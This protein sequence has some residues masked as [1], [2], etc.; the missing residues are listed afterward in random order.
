M[1]CSEIKNHCHPYLDRQLDAAQCQEVDAHLSACPCCQK[2]FEAQRTFLVV[3]KKLTQT[4]AGAAP[5][6]LR[7]RISQSLIAGHAQ[8]EFKPLKKPLA[9]PRM[10]W[11]VGMAASLMLGFSALLAYQMLCIDGACPI[12][13][14]AEQEHEKI[15]SGARAVLAKDSDAKKLTAA[16]QAQLPAFPGLPNLA[17]YNL[18]PTECGLVNLPPLQKTTGNK[19]SGVFVRYVGS[20][21]GEPLTLMMFDTN[22]SS[23]APVVDKEA[24]YHMAIREK[25]TV[26]SWRCKKSG[27][28]YVLVTR[29]QQGDSL[30]IAEFASN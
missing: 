29:R 12:V 25:H 9:L 26:C 15:V 8:P 18:T 5:A 1:N 16:I 7:G 22:D 10:G 13:I 30:A 20:G 3:L 27:L 24:K 21:D 6:D 19:S 2:A 4:C 17:K 14:A 23:R 11:L 28:L